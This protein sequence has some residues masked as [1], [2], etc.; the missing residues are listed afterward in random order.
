MATVVADLDVRVMV[1]GVRDPGHGIHKGHGLVV[2]AE[3]EAA[4]D[5]LAAGINR[6]VVMK[7]LY[8]LCGLFLC[9]RRRAAIECL[10]VLGV[11]L[12]L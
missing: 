11:Y 2:I 5:F 6:P 9:Q 4:V 1:L 7:L 3:L 12:N 8:Q 10:A